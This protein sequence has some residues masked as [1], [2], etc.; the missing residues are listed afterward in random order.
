MLNR[1]TKPWFLVPPTWAHNLSPYFLKAISPFVVEENY[2]W[3]EKSWRHIHFRN[4]LGLA[5]GVDKNIEQV[6]AWAR[7]GCGFL[8][9]GTITPLPQQANPGKILARDIS[10]QALWNKMGFPNKGLD[11]AIRKL[12]NLSANRKVPIFA[13]IG[14][15]RQTPN[16][17]AADDYKACIRGLESLVDAFVVNISSPNT[18]NLRDLLEPQVLKPFLQEVVSARKKPTPILLKL[19]PDLD[20]EMLKNILGVSLEANMDGWIFTNTTLQRPGSL[21][22]PPEGGLSGQPL[23]P[24]SKKIL[25]SALDHMGAQ[26]GDRLVISVGGIMNEQD[27]IDRLELGADLV[28]V[29]SALIFHGPLFFKQ[30]LRKLKNFEQHSNM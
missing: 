21:S 8:E 20:D 13:N 29:Y 17:H 30:S 22:F 16:E 14:K 25:K 23:A 6:E 4:P 11:Q 26:R 5:G 28:Q 1:W 24:F 19:S 9:V 18:K 10:Q 7:L 2:Q 27:I 12:E 3:R 15:N